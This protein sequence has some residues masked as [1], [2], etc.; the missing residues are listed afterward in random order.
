MSMARRGSRRGAAAL[1]VLACVLGLVAGTAAVNAQ[2][3]VHSSG[4]YAHRSLKRHSADLD[5][6]H[7]GQHRTICVSKRMHAVRGFVYF[8]DKLIAMEV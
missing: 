3:V 6:S 4:R 1:V 5:A 2:S 7:A 8:C